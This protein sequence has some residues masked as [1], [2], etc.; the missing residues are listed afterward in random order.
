MREQKRISGVTEATQ[1]DTRTDARLFESLCPSL[2][3][4][5]S[6]IQPIIHG[7]ASMDS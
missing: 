1:N 5:V 7:R 2:S 3:F 6:D 4:L